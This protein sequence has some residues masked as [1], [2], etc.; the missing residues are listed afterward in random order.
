MSLGQPLQSW[1]PSDAQ[2]TRVANWMVAWTMRSLGR[3]DE[4]LEIQLRLEREGD[5]AAA[6]DPYVF[7]ELEH[8][9]RQKHD[10]PRARHYA[11]RKQSLAR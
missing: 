1:Q 7:E 8:L 11:D 10:E 9:Y 6:P 4:A 5:A 3:I 2:A